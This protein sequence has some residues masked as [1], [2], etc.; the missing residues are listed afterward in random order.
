[1]SY[2]VARCSELEE[3]LKEARTLLHRIELDIRDTEWLL[4][5]DS[6]NYV[7][8]HYEWL[9]SKRVE[10]EEEVKRTRVS[11]KIPR[12][13]RDR[14]RRVSRGYS[15]SMSFSIVFKSSSVASSVLKPLTP[16]SLAACG[17]SCSGCT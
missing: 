11:I 2:S 3:K 1:V 17:F 7:R 13:G 9:K 8:E 12:K 14:L 10:L 5:V 16:R 4:S 6:R 15:F